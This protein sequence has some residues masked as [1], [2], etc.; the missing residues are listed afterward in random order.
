MW[1][2]NIYAKRDLEKRR[3]CAESNMQKRRLTLTKFELD[4]LKKISWETPWCQRRPTYVKKDHDATWCH[5]NL[6]FS[7]LLFFRLDFVSFYLSFFLFLFVLVCSSYLFFLLFPP[8][9]L[10][11]WAAHFSQIFDRFSLSLKRVLKPRQTCNSLSTFDVWIRVRRDISKKSP[12]EA[13]NEY[14]LSNFQ[15]YS[16]NECDW[17]NT[18]QLTLIGSGKECPKRTR[19]EWDAGVENKNTQNT[20]INLNKWKLGEP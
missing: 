18:K 4:Q 15:Q 13:C 19:G 6:T 12:D 8:F 1:A 5:L 9:S 14:P 16:G 7:C 3:V 17:T 2:E 20:Q 11:D 10:Q